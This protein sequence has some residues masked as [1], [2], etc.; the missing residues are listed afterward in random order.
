MHKTAHLLGL[1]GLIPFV[2]LTALMHQPWAA[3]YF[4]PYSAVILSFLGG[5]HWGVALQDPRWSNSWRLS[6]CMLPSL[7]GWVALTLPLKESL[8]L[9]MIAYVLWWIYDYSQIK[10]DD[11][12]RLRRCLSV[13]VIVCHGSWL[14]FN[15]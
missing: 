13:V 14:F 12:R 15:F 8:I 4:L 10:V 6:L 5:I 2:G 9:L 3:T 1:S 11:Y 7:I